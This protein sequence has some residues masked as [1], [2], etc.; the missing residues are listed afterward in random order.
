MTAS[1]C[2]SGIPCPAVPCQRRVACGSLSFFSPL[3]GPSRDDRV[4]PAASSVHLFWC[5]PGK[6]RSVRCSHVTDHDSSAF[7]G[8]RMER[9]CPFCVT[10][11]FSRDLAFG[12]PD[13]GLRRGGLVTRARGGQTG[14]D[15]AELCW[16]LRRAGV[17]EPRGK[18]RPSGQPFRRPSHASARTPATGFAGFGS[19][20]R[21]ALCMSGYAGR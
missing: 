8:R 15:Y 10:G 2:L 13:T 3:A 20:S 16:S 1:L 21:A 4:H 19:V 17:R 14:C 11:S 7:F 12:Q 5:T 6:C 9:R 18:H